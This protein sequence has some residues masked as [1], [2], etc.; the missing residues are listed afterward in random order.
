MSL[1]SLFLPAKISHVVATVSEL[2]FGITINAAN[3][4]GVLP[5]GNAYT[6]I[7]DIV[8]AI[9]MPVTAWVISANEQG[10]QASSAPTPGTAVVQGV[11]TSSSTAS[12][13]PTSPK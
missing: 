6:M 5:I 11:G 8:I 7:T 10:I 4:F 12:L 13:P 2:A 9:A 1:A 3:Y